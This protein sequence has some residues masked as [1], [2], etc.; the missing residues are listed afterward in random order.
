MAAIYSAIALAACGALEGKAPAGPLNGPSQWIYGRLAAHR[1]RP[2]FRY[3]LVGYAI[4][5]VVS[6][7]WATLHEKHVA[8][9]LGRRSTAARFG[10][11]AI[12]AALACSVDY[13]VAKGRA[14]PGFEKQ[15]S[16]KS[17]FAVY[18]AFAVGLAL[19]PLGR[20]AAAS[21]ICRNPLTCLI[22]GSRLKRRSHLHILGGSHVDCMPTRNA[23]EKANGRQEWNE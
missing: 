15:L 4:H 16:R 23:A 5:H 6:V 18:A 10:A 19:W 2:S 20:Q 12:T 14:Q 1:R 11:A 8:G 21:R 7:G 9:L 13:Q 17:L 3:T 22:A